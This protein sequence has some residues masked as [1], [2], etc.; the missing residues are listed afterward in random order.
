MRF[1]S[2]VCVNLVSALAVFAGV[3]QAD[4]P[5]PYAVPTEVITV[6]KAKG[7]KFLDA[8]FSVAD[9]KFFD[10]SYTTTEGSWK[11][12]GAGKDKNKSI[13]K[14]RF[15]KGEDTIVLTG[16]CL[17]RSE[18]NVSVFQISVD[19]KN[20]GLYKCEFADVAAADYAL[21]VVVPQLAATKM[22]FMT[23]ENDDPHRWDVVKAKMRYKGV[24]Y[25]A[26]PTGIDKQRE[27]FHR[28]PIM[29]YV[30]SRDGKPVGRLDNDF[31]G[32]QS[33]LA[34]KGKITAPVSDADGREAVIF[35]A[36]EL[37]G[38]PEIMKESNAF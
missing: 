33:D 14:F 22:G 35:F 28:Q 26:V 29:G 8:G 6:G 34:P 5:A 13:I 20:S 4:E 19:S 38:M 25:E 23:I 9:Y 24:E 12:F 3:T 2:R 17:I 11:V 31:T 16:K 32:F 7:G 30:I 27:A 21:E 10:F 1:I 18:A 15:V 37:L 36:S